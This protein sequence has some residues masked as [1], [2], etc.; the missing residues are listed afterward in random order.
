MRSSII[1]IL[2]IW[3]AAYIWGCKKSQ[4][5]PT[6]TARK[7]TVDT[8]KKD[9]PATDTSTGL[10]PWPSSPND[11]IIDT[12]RWIT[13]WYNSLEIPNFT[14]KIPAGVSYK[15]FIKRGNSSNWVEVPLINPSDTTAKPYEYFVETR[16]DGAGI[17]TFGSLYIFYYGTNISD[18]PAVK[19]SY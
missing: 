12:L 13:P 9:K 18:R 2:F 6:D 17:Y 14:K 8:V 16:A 4:T 3:M 5:E 10:V 1:C 7:P 15:V 11:V 19:I